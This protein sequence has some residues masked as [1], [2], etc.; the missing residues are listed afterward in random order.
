MPSSSPSSE[1]AILQGDDF[2][3]FS[4]G[5]NFDPKLVDGLAALNR[6]STKAAIVEVFGALSDSPIASAR[7]TVRLPQIRPGDLM[8]LVTTL[9]RNGIEFNYL[10]NTSQS[11]DDA[12]RRDVSTYLRKLS[13]IGVTRFT[14]GTEELCQLAKDTL[15]NSHVTMSITRGIRSTEAIAYAEIAGADAAYVDGV[16]VNRDFPLLRKLVSASR[17]ETRVYANMSCVSGCPVVRRHYGQF[18]GPQSAAT[19]TTSDAYFAGCSLVKLRSPVEWIQMPWIRP[20][21][22]SAYMS[23]G[24]RLFKLSDRLAP[25]PVLLRIAEAYLS[26]ESPSDLFELMERDGGKYRAF[27][28]EGADITGPPMSVRSDCIPGNFIEH[29]R[30]GSCRSRDRKCLVCNRIANLAVKINKQWIDAELAPEVRSVVPIELLSRAGE[31]RVS[32]EPN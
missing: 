3:R 21:D 23:E 8:S 32:L 31:R 16:F 24:V 18:A 25:T 22:V 10:M 7:P 30:Q 1:S 11:L 26:E 28:N 6:N 20:E 13:S 19:V 5:C 4:I 17:I 15:P 14:V 2:P 12:L 29:F 9:S 27:R